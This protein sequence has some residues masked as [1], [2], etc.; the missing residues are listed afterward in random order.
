MDVSLD[1]ANKDTVSPIDADDVLDEAL[2][3]DPG[4]SGQVE[5]EDEVIVGTSWKRAVNKPSAEEVR[6]H[7]ISH[8]PYRSWCEHC[9]RGKAKDNPHVRVC[10]EEWETEA[11]HVPQVKRRQWGFDIRFR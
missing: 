6:R 4:P 7:M 1:S 11:V 3:P 8:V 5:A 9:V 10:R 2:G